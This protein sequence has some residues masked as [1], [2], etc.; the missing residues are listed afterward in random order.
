M[1]QTNTLKQGKKY[2]DGNTNSFEEKC[3]KTVNS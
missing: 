2:F 1:S 3:T